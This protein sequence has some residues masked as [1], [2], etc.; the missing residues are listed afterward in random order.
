MH[1]LQAKGTE[2]TFN[3]LIVENFPIL[4]KELP[5]QVQEVCRTLNRNV[6][7]RILPWLIILK[8]DHTYR[9][10]LFTTWKPMPLHKH[11]EQEKNI[12]G[13]KR[14]KSNNT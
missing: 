11:R 3:K 5:I 2:N 9:D 12:E 14:E 7:N 13:C 8:T 10:A 4:E 6:Q 1:L